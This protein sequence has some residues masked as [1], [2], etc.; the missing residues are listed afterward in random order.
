MTLRAVLIDDEPL[1]RE[2]LR[3]M[4]GE[5]GRDVEIVG[6]AGSG[7]EAVPLVHETRPDVVFLDVQMPVLDGFDVVDLLAPPR[8]H[9]VF[10]TAYDEF[11]L[12]AFEVHAL[13]YLTKPVG[14]DRLGHALD[15]TAALV[16]AGTADDALERLRT[17][18]GEASLERVTVRVGHTLRVVDVGEVAA[19]EARDK[20]VYVRA[21]GREWPVDFTIEE[22][23]RRLPADRFVQV[24]RA[25]VV[26]VGAVRELAPWYG[27]T[28]RLTLTDGTEVPVA[29]RRV[30][31]L[32]ARYGR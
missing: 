15:R 22:L 31:E 24:H 23:A 29:R 16:A 3:T 8:P 17:E 12:R 26:R 21:G 13:D 25:F 6:E 32:K 9:V 1:A 27:G 28:Y 5:S 18:R 14:A 4:L 19:F 2:R 7:R 30:R 10:V 11:A 20:L